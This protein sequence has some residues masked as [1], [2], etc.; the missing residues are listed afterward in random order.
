VSATARTVAEQIDQMQ[1]GM[2]SSGRLPAEVA[3]TFG[4]EQAALGAAGIPD[5]VLAPGVPMPDGELLDVH[6]A[7]TTLTGARDG[8]P[9]V[10]VLYRG[11]WCPYCNLTLRAYEQQLLPDLT[12]RGVS[13]IAISPQTPDGSLSAVEANQLTYTVLSDPGNQIAKALGVRFQPGEDARAAQ[14]ELGLDTSVVNADGT[15]ELP[16]PTVALVDANGILRWIDVH[17][18]YTIRTEPAAILA[19]VDAVL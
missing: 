9:A 5:G 7:S 14:R 12:P 16:M 4:A 11:A 2:R 15:S 6:G 3:A 19:A 8:G 18:N 13:L 17:P 1:E 10:V